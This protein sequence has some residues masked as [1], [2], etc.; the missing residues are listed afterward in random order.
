MNLME[1]KRKTEIVRNLNVKLS[2][3]YDSVV[4]KNEPLFA[5]DDGTLFRISPFPGE[6]AV[7]VEYAENTEGAYKNQFEDGDR[8]Y[9]DS[10]DEEELFITIIQEI[11]R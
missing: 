1:Q 2:S 11:E 7:V 5:K 4:V 6:Y 10:V 3:K 9:L 8:F